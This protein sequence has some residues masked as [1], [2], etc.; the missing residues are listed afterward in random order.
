[1]SSAL[2][3]TKYKAKPSNQDIPPF[4]SK[5]APYIFAHRGGM[6]V[7]PE[8]TK[9]AFDNAVT[10]GIDGFETDVRLTKD[11]KLIVFHDLDVDRTTNGSGKV[12][13]HTLSELKRLDSGYHFIDINGLKP[14]RGHKD[15]YIL[16]FDE[17]LKLYPQQLINVDL[18]DDPD[19]EQGRLA[20]E[21]IYDDIVANNAQDRVLVTSFHSKQ[22]ERFNIISNGTVAIGASQR[23]VT[24]GFLKFHLGLGNTFQPR[25]HTFQMPS[26]FKGVKLTSPKFIQWL[27]T[28]N[29]IPGYYGIN[30]LDLMNDLIFYGTHTLVTD[31]PDL[32]KRFKQ[33]YH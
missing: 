33:T 11:L 20:P 9:L 26:T 19:T 16:S 17:L 15:A 30:N 27:N 31:R 3:I 18:K 13:E 23:E 2:L 14:Y 24:E 32:A 5:P 1:M 8:Q 7:R 12:S 29:I 22:I 21:I 6:A 10:H 25:A 28:R 4:F